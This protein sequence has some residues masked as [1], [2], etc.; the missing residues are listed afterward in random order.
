MLLIPDSLIQIV[1][2]FQYGHFHSWTSNVPGAFRLT[3]NNAVFF[4]INVLQTGDGGGI[5]VYDGL[6]RLIWVMPTAFTGSFTPEG[7]CENG[8]IVDNG[9][10]RTMGSNIAVNWRE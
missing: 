3:H 4:A 10:G 2:P 1:Q 8:I 6:R 9:Y 5:E 7:Y